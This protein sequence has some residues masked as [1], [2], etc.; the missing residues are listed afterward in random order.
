[1]GSFTTIERPPVNTLAGHG[2]HPGWAS[3][4]PTPLPP[5]Q[6]GSPQGSRR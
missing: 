4:D 1:L 3:G 2:A 5:E 6:P